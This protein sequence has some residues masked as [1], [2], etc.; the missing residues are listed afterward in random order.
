VAYR[1]GDESAPPRHPARP[2]PD[3]V[4]LT[5]ALLGLTADRREVAEA[6]RW[7]E[8]PDRILLALWWLEASGQLT[9]AEVVAAVEQPPER[10]DARI[11][12]LRA[13]LGVGRRIV[14][15]LAARPRCAE[16]TRIGRT[17]DGA[18]TA[19]WRRRFARHLRGCAYCA[20][21]GALL[22]DPDQVLRG[23]PLL[24]PAPG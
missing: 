16:L 4:D 24:T 3:F 8:P 22:A 10:V 18:T 17:W 20:A 23:L 2:V 14:R 21:P 6:T 5:I 1:S 19:L 12:R 7:V 9:R 11:R 15:A 13:L